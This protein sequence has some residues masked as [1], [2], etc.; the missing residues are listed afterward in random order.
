MSRKV[1]AK[2]PESRLVGALFG[3]V[4]RPDGRIVARLQQSREIPATENR[5]PTTKFHP[6]HGILYVTPS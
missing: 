6:T 1:T 5:F 2:S 3:N 4:I